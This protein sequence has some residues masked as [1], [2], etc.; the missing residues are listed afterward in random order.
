MTKGQKIEP[1]LKKIELAIDKMLSEGFD[2][3]NGFVK[4]DQDY[5]NT[6]SQIEGKQYEPPAK[7]DL[8]LPEDNSVRPANTET[9]KQK[10]QAQ[11]QNRPKYLTKQ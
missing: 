9:K 10:E 5:L 7:V 4:A 8:P 3:Q 1:M 2:S 6:K 11:K